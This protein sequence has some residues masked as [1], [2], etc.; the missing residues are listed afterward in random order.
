MRSRHCAMCAFDGR[1]RIRSIVRIARKVFGSRS[2]SFRHCV[3]RRKS[4]VSGCSQLRVLARHAKALGRPAMVPPESI[5]SSISSIPVPLTESRRRNGKAPF[6]CFGYS[7][8]SKSCG[9]TGYDALSESGGI[10][11]RVE[12]YAGWT[13]LANLKAGR[14]DLA[15][16]TWA[17][18]GSFDLADLLNP[19]PERLL[20]LLQRCGDQSLAGRCGEYQRSQ[21]R[22][23]AFRIF[24]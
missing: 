5:G 13:A 6:H 22:N 16:M 20:G 21:G 1:L 9:V 17:S 19:F 24:W 23:R 4:A 2:M 18:H 12:E 14:V 7:K 3:I 11:S 10:D 15:H 8:L